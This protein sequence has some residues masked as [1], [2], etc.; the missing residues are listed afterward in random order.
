[1]R[2]ALGSVLVAAAVGV[3]LA[4]ATVVGGTAIIAGSKPEPVSKP[5][6][7]YGAR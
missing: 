6:Y 5:L 2:D 3:A 7:Q 1:M 4:V